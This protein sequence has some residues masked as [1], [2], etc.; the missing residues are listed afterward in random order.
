MVPLGMA[1]QFPGPRELP[2]AAE[3]AQGLGVLALCKEKGW[4]L[5]RC[6]K[7]E[8]PLAPASWLPAARMAL[9]QGLRMHSLSSEAEV[10]K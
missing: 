5:G 8:V 10:Q 9:F 2:P 6:V 1:Q 4:L 3:A 7:A